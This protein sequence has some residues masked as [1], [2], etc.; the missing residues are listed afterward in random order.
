M[1]SPCSP[2]AAADCSAQS[3]LA[4]EPSATSS[5]SLTAAES[6]RSASK[7][8]FST[9]HQSIVGLSETLLT[10]VTRAYIRKWLTCSPLVSP[11]RR[12]ASQENG[13]ANPT[14]E[15]AGPKPSLQSESRIQDFAGL[16]MFLVSLPTPISKRYAAIFAKLGIEYVRPCLAESTS[17][18]PI[19]ENG[20][21]FWRTPTNGDASHGANWDRSVKQGQGSLVTQ[22]KKWPTP[23]TQCAKFSR[24]TPPLSAAVQIW[25]TPQNHDSH[26]GQ[27]D[28]AER[29][30]ARADCRNLNDEVAKRELWPTPKASNGGPDYAK[31]DRS[32]TGISLQTAVNLFPTPV[33]QDSHGHQQSGTLPGALGLA[34]GTLNPE[35]VEWLMG[36]PIGWSSLRPLVT[37]KFRQWW[38]QHGMF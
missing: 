12:S 20:S 36:W 30:T 13:S 16:K 29:G 33:K 3:S 19:S 37:D 4:G 24:N 2:V 21:G 38:R 35:W 28:R 8:G 25:P 15:T 9:T 14:L 31:L 10:A 34:G 17:E 23:T 1:N 27:A 18:R 26:P 22:V 7:T 32:A 6:S 5:A 11:A